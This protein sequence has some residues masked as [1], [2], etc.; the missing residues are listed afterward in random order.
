[1]FF[2]NISKSFILIFLIPFTLG[3]YNRFYWWV[4]L[5][6]LLFDVVI[7]VVKHSLGNKAIIFQ[8]PV[9]ASGCNILCF[10]SNDEGK[11]GFPSGHTASTTMMLLI[12]A[13]Y[14]NDLRFTV[15]AFVYIMLMALSRHTKRCH[16]WAQ[17]VSGFIFG[18]I[19]AMIFIRLIP[20]ETST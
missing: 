20:K 7:G 19:G 18:V 1:M 2:E 3:L 5:G 12:L 14:I 8:R 11:P 13:Y 17:I 10:P 16:N 4:L 9:G 6:V 15:F